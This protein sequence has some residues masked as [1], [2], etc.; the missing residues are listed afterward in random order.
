MNKYN[1]FFKRGNA[2]ENW[3]PKIS[4]LL[5]VLV[6]LQAIIMSEEV[7]FNEPGFEG[8][9]GTEEGE[10]KNEAYSNIVRYCNVKFAMVDQ[11]KNPSKGFEN[12]I[13]RHFYLKKDEILKEC[14]KWLKF[15][16]VRDASYTGLIYD[17]N[18]SWCEMF[19]KDKKTYYNML[20][21]AIKELEIELDK[22]QP[23]SSK[24]L[25]Q[26]AIKKIKQN[27]TKKKV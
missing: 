21:E 6:S 16:E 13:R 14:Y 19:R 17:H 3:D 9:A 1:K 25:K 26:K 20:N 27:V 22:L 2:T 4:T 11:L 10:K 5:Q 12:A 15:A 7:Y 24:D 23:P 8:E 18:R